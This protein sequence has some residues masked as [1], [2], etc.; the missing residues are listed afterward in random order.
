MKNAYIYNSDYVY[1]LTPLGKI[2]DM[3]CDQINSVIAT[4]ADSLSLAKSY[5]TLIDGIIYK[6]TKSIENLIPVD[7]KKPIKIITTERKQLPQHYQDIYPSII[8]EYFN[9][10]QVTMEILFKTALVRSEFQPIIDSQEVKEQLAN[11]GP[12]YIYEAIYN[13]EFP[14]KEIRNYMKTVLK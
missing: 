5:K 10:I 6:G 9:R 3:T 11:F 13:Y 12:N 4:K 14:H 2:F 8:F 7:Y 1:I